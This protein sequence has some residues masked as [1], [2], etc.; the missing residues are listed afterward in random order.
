MLLLSV[1]CLSFPE[2]L[3]LLIKVIKM[4]IESTAFTHPMALACQYDNDSKHYIHVPHNNSRFV[5]DIQRVKS[6]HYLL[7]C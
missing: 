2:P 1:P 4:I 7:K 6:V 5:Y 3:D